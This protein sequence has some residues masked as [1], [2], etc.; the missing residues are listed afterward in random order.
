MIA[1]RIALAFLALVVGGI[2][3]FLLFFI[4]EG[5]NNA[6]LAYAANTLLFALAAYAYTRTEPGWWLAYALL[7][8]GPVLLISLGGA[9]GAAALLALLMTAI[10]VG[11]GFLAWT[12]APG[13]VTTP[14]ADAGG[15]APS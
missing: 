10:T 1:K 11:V 13:G 3:F 9:S 8:C 6:L 12:R 5:T 15:P 4:G 14:P 2:G 7:L